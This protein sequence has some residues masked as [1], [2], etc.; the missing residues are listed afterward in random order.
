[1]EMQKP[2]SLAASSRKHPERA[3]T[4]PRSAE[5]VWANCHICKAGSSRHGSSTACA[6]GNALWDRIVQGSC[7]PIQEPAGKGL[8]VFIL[9]HSALLQGR[10]QPTQRSIESV[11]QILAIDAC[12][13]DKVQTDL[14]LHATQGSICSEQA[15]GQGSNVTHP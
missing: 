11:A 5:M 15:G 4:H 7:S 13:F 12:S 6:A 9:T 3:G 10:D 2:M 1:M 14:V 8:S